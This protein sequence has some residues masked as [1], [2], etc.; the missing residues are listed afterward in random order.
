[1]VAINSFGRS[2]N[3][4][5]WIMLYIWFTVRTDGPDELSCAEWKC[6]VRIKWNYNCDADSAPFGQF[7]LFRG[8]CEPLS[9]N[10]SASREANG[11]DSI[12]YACNRQHNLTTAL[13]WGCAQ[14]IFRGSNQRFA[15]SMSCVGDHFRFLRSAHKPTA[16]E[17][18]KIH[19]FFL[20]FN[21]G[22]ARLKLILIPRAHGIHEHILV[23]TFAAVFSLTSQP[24][25]TQHYC[26]DLR[27]IN[28]LR[29]LLFAF[30]FSKLRSYNFNW[31]S[32]IFP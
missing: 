17:L 8:S 28:C 31:P 9:R 13:S 22:I 32:A 25:L 3:A 4:F 27:N 2:S 29:E 14:M 12:S 6:I 23:S 26:Y 20:N 30:H 5:C 15:I 21:S 18:T 11:R 24:S 10:G 7:Y 16:V 19:V 1:M